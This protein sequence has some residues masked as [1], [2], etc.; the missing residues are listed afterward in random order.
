[1]KRAINH[2]LRPPKIR[3]HFFDITLL[4]PR[5]ELLCLLEPG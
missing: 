1:M 2:F 4:V 5:D 3:V